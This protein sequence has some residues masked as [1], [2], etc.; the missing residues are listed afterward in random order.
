M[1]IAISRRQANHTPRV[2][3]LVQAFVQLVR[4]VDVHRLWLLF[5]TLSK[6]LEVMQVDGFIYIIEP[7]VFFRTYLKGQHQ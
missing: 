2:Q 3:I 7:R 1:V 4:A 5:E 6:C